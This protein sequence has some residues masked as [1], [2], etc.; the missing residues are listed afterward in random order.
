MDYVEFERPEANVA[1]AS[2]TRNFDF[3]VQLKGKGDE[4]GKRLVV[5]K[6]ESE[7]RRIQR[8]IQFLF[9]T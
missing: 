9:K 4:A 3:S 1:G 5:R 8:E 7:K 2:V 6:I